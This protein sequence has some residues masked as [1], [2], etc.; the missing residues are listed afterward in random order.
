MKEVFGMSSIGKLKL[1]IW[2]CLQHPKIDCF[3]VFGF[4]FY[5]SLKQQTRY[6]RK[7]K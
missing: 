5:V 1:T 4:F 2:N 7:F 6:F 3:N